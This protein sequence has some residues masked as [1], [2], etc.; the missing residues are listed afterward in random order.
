MPISQDEK[1]KRVKNYVSSKNARQQPSSF[2]S[3]NFLQ[4]YFLLSTTKSFSLNI[5]KFTWWFSSHLKK[6]EEK[7][8]NQNILQKKLKN[9][10]TQIQDISKCYT[11]FYDTTQAFQESAEQLHVQQLQLGNELPPLFQYILRRFYVPRQ[12]SKERQNLFRIHCILFFLL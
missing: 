8:C 6:V 3:N 5:P 2:N 10:L 7:T 9:D 1:K 4:T 11:M 12:N